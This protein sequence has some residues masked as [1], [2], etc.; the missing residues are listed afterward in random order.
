MQKTTIL[1]RLSFLFGVV[2]LFLSE[3]VTAQIVIGAPNLG[4]TQAC[5]SELF[6]SYNVTFVFSPE[7]NLSPTNQ[8]IIEMSD[9]VGSFASPTVVF[10]SSAGAV[11]TSPATLNFSLSVHGIYIFSFIGVHARC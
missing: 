9:A 1:K 10:T 8:F 3:Q 4:F 2:A 7:S 11:T 5:A 6:N